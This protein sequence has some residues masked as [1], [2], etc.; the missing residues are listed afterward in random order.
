MPP[1][2]AV[3]PSHPLLLFSYLEPTPKTGWEEGA[4]EKPF[5]MTCW[6]RKPL[7]YRIRLSLNHRGQWCRCAISLV[8]LSCIWHP[9]IYSQSLLLLCDVRR[10]PIPAFPSRALSGWTE[11]FPRLKL[12]LAYI[13]CKA[14]G[15]WWRSHTLILVTGNV[16]FLLCAFLLWTLPF[17]V[18]YL[19]PL[20]ILSLSF[21]SQGFPFVCLVLLW[22]AGIYLS[23]VCCICTSPG[24]M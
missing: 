11:V 1:S 12:W 18:I 9:W 15:A 5:F 4:P 19:Y 6:V 3:V 24:G 17:M 16:S 21:F 20:F 7:K 14:P 23:G 2:A 10:V 8:H 22:C 13:V